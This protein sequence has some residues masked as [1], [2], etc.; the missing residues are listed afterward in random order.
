MFEREAP[1]YVPIKRSSRYKERKP[2]KPPF[3]YFGLGIGQFCVGASFLASSRLRDTSYRLR[4]YL[5]RLC[6]GLSPRN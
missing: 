5:P 4:R 3:F 6:F 1:F 2:L